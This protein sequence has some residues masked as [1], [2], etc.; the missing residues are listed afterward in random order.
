[1]IINYLLKKKKQQQQQLQRVLVVI[2]IKINR[3]LSAPPEPPTRN[4]LPPCLPR[5]I[6]FSVDVQLLAIIVS[7]GLAQR[8]FVLVVVDVAVLR[9]LVPFALFAFAA[10]CLS[11]MAVI[12]NCIYA[13]QKRPSVR[14]GL[15]ACPFVGFSFWLW[16]F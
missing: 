5:R 6:I 4:L 12:I 16:Q 3:R 9:S 15:T 1:M 7:R 2:L 14:F 13:K 8:H 10:C 11:Y